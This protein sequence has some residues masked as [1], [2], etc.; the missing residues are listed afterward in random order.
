MLHYPPYGKLAS[1]II[2]GSNQQQVAKVAAMFG[3]TAPNTAYITT[4]GPAPAPLFLLRDK[5]R[6]RLLLKTERNINI[7]KVLSEWRQMVQ[8]PSNV[9]VEIDIDPYSFM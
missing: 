6:Y 5:Y 9:R 8:V 4:L 2:S 7:Q 3:Q 1:L